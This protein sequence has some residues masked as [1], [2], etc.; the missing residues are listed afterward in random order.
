MPLH[1]LLD[2]RHLPDKRAFVWLNA[3]YLLSPKISKI[4]RCFQHSG[5][6]SQRVKGETQRQDKN[7]AYAV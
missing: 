6:G 5:L 2:D 7:C 4:M 3:R 1:N